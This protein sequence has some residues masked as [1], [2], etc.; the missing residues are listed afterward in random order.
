[1]TIRVRASDGSIAEFPDDAS[2]QEISRAMRQLDQ[3]ID[4]RTRAGAN[5]PGSGIGAMVGRVAVDGPQTTGG[6]VHGNLVR[7]RAPRGR[8]GTALRALEDFNRGPLEFLPQM[9]R[10]VGVAD[11]VSGWAAQLRAG[12]NPE[13]YQAGVDFERSQQQRVARE[14]PGVNAA[15]IAASIPA[16]GGTPV[17]LARNPTMLQAGAAAAGVNAPFALARQEGSLLERLPGAGA[18]S[19]VA[20]GLGSALQGGANYFSRAA[21]PNSTAARAAEFEQ[22]GVRAPLAAVQGRQGAPMAM[23][24]AENPIGGNVRRHLQ[25]SADDVAASARNLTARAGSPEP[26]EMAGEAVQRGIERFN[27]GGIPQPRRGDPAAIPTR[28]WSFRSKANALYDDVFEVI[29]RDEAGHLAGQTG[30]RATAEHARQALR[31]IQARV[32]APNLAEIVND[33][34]IAR[35]ATALADDADS[36]RFNDLRALRTW[37]R[38]ARD[39]RNMTQ[40]IDEASLA[41][42]E[43]ALTADIYDSAITLGGEYAARRLHLVDRY[44]RAGQQRIQ[45]ALQP[46]V[47]RGSQRVGG[48]QA[49]RRVIELASQGG[50]QNTRQLAQLRASLRPDEWRVVSASIMDELGRPG[51]GS[52]FAMEAGEFSLEHFVTNVAKLSPQGRR[53]LFGELADD[54]ERLARVAGALKRVRGFT[55]YSRSGSSLQNMSTLTALGGAGVA[56]GTGNIAPLAMLAGAGLLARVTGEMLTNPGFVRW[57]TKAGAGGMRRQISGL[58]ALA[59]RDPALVPLYTELA[60]NAAGRSPQAGERSPALARSPAMSGAQ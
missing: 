22:A 56:A 15:S 18:E 37:V 48:A 27:E 1:M 40:T 25:N 16:F 11:E 2:E 30:A 41:R 60:Q 53:A 9:M 46:F 17:A 14:Q 36:L 33:P 52:P 12:G 45:Q 47:Q 28:E 6:R 24:I 42:L 35:I 19:T 51:F 34:A 26:R 50:R 20:F 5:G 58:A 4:A 8:P 32:Q 43:S 13:A 31:D 49:Y 7:E 44:Y 38:E 59:A 21:R 23:A 10:N 3:E 39:G 57:L 55:N 54:L 29:T